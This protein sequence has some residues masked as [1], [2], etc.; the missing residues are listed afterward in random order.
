MAAGERM[1]TNNTNYG[2]F[3]AGAIIG[4]AIAILY[5]PSAGKETRELIGK[6]ADEGRDALNETSRELMEKSKELYE[7]GRQLAEEAADLFER[8]RQ[9]V[10]G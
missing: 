1:A 3:A 9:L 7:R 8:G 10:R 2:W 6:K 5:A 4:A